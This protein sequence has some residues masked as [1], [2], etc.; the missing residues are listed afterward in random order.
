MSKNISD[1]LKIKADLL[2]HL[3]TVE[4]MYI[5]HVPSSGIRMVSLTFD[6]DRV[7]NDLDPVFSPMEWEELLK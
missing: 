5:N 3:T 2:R 7:N 6:I 4:E 1:K